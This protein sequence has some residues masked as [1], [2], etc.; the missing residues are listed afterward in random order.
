MTVQKTD[1][2]HVLVIDKLLSL[3]KVYEIFLW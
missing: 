2:I 1:E 3:E